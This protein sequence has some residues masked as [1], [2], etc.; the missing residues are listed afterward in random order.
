LLCPQD[1]AEVYVVLPTLLVS[2]GKV[3]I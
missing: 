3:S 1:R 2:V